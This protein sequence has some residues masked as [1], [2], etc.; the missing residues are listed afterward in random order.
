MGDILKVKDADGNWRS[1]PAIT[2]MSAYELAVKNGFT[3]TEGEWLESLK[4]EPGEKGDT[5][6]QGQPGTN[7]TDGKDGKDG[8]DGA[9]GPQGPAGEGIPAGGVAGQVL[10]K[11]T[12]T[13]FDTQWQDFP[14]TGVISFNGR[15]GAVKPASGDYTASQVGAL[16]TS[17]GTVSGTL[18]MGGTIE[19][20]TSTANQTTANNNIALQGKTTHANSCVKLQRSAAEGTAGYAQLVFYNGTGEP[21]NPCRLT[22]IAAPT[23]GSDATNKTY[24]DGAVSTA[25]S[26]ITPNVSAATGILPIANGGTG[27]SSAQTALYNLINGRAA[28]TSTG[29]ATGDYIPV[30]DVSASTGKRI[31][32]ENLKAALGVDSS[33]GGVVFGT[34]VGNQ[35]RPTTTGTALQTPQTITLGFQPKFVWVGQLNE[36]VNLIP[37]YEDNEFIYP[38]SERYANYYVIACSAY[39]T[40]SK[41]Y[42]ARQGG[43]SGRA[44]VNP[45]TVTTTGFQV[46]NSNY[47]TDDTSLSPKEYV[48]RRALFNYNNYTYFYLA[49]K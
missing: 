48:Q 14:E 16:P 33:G 29:I 17:G 7:G 4:G 26:G 11:K 21:T 25:V 36:E 32:L 35:S 38:S 18:T 44:T 23:A 22:G 1:I 3:G 9:S 15:S 37:W 8:K 39:A 12:G 20:M 6:A 13:D 24:V 46:A 27:A 45:L 2:G 31:T 47:S 28:L 34:Y 10:T 41:P 40:P 19:A 5:G 49:L 42:Q 43:D 30:Q